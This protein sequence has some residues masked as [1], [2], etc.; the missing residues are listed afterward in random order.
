MYTRHTKARLIQL[1]IE[2]NR[3]RNVVH[4]YFHHNT[5]NVHGCKL[6][7]C[8]QFNISTYILYE[9]HNMIKNIDFLTTKNEQFFDFIYYTN[10]ITITQYTRLKLNKISEI[11]ED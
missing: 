4:H 3:R 8:L 7:I 6:L 1:K 11:M 10:Y 2:N 5:I 9:R